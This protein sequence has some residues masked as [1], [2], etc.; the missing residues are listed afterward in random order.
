LF[1][2]DIGRAVF[3]Y[4]EMIRDLLYSP[5]GLIRPQFKISDQRS[6]AASTFIN[7]ELVIQ[8]RSGNLFGAWQTRME[9]LSAIPDPDGLLSAAE[10]HYESDPEDNIFW[11]VYQRQDINGSPS[12]IDYQNIS[13]SDFSTIFAQTMPDLIATEQ[14]LRSAEVEKKLMWELAYQDCSK[15]H[16]ARAVDHSAVKKIVE[17]LGWKLPPAPDSNN[18][19]MLSHADL[20][21]RNI[22]KTS[23][24]Y[25]L[26][27]WESLGNYSPSSAFGHLFAWALMKIP[28]QN[29]ADFLEDNINPCLPLMEMNIE[30]A[31]IDIYWRIIR[32][33]LYWGSDLSN[34][35][36]WINESSRLLEE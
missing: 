14:L 2:P 18:Q 29:W 33:A 27:D 30:E 13:F 31:K 36:F 20:I 19:L 3:I 28:A 12:Q 25:R 9:I 7:E 6:Y 16:L 23:S 26:I 35:D 32:E 21:P 34:L 24:G 4:I 1:V 10:C 5:S 22:I 15:T 17:N 8:R 11:V